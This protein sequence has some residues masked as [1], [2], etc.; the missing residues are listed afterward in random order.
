MNSDATSTPVRSTYTPEEVATILGVSTR[1]VYMICK[2]ETV[3]KTIKLGKRCLRIH[4]ESFDAWFNGQS[5]NH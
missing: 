1:K 4:K 2:G 5:E 3:F